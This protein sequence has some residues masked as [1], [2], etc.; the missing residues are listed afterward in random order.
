MFAPS[1]C[2][3]VVKVMLFFL[4]YLHFIFTFPVKM[5]QNPHSPET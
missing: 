3:T 4:L 2:Y 1:Q 5:E